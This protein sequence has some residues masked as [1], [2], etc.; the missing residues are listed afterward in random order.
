MEVDVS[1]IR[2]FSCGMRSVQWHPS[3]ISNNR[4]DLPPF[5]IRICFYRHSVCPSLIPS[6]FYSVFLS[7]LLACIACVENI[8]ARYVY[9]DFQAKLNW[10]NNGHF[11][12]RPEISPEMSTIWIFTPLPAWLTAHVNISV[13]LVY[14]EW[15]INSPVHHCM[16]TR[17]ARSARCLP[18]RRRVDEI[19]FVV[20]CRSQQMWVKILWTAFFARPLPQ[21]YGGAVK[22]MAKNKPCHFQIA[23]FQFQTALTV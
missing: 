23:P 8:P 3:N 22:R 16:R 10:W 9:L 15:F 20:Y 14:I 4:P 6:Q 1:S 12:M 17:K 21:Q 11:P 13:Q 2:R 5:V 19:N 18:R 7:L